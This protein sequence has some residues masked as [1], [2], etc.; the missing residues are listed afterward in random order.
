MNNMDAWLGDVEA[1]D[2]QR[3]RIDRAATAIERRYPVPADGEPSDVAEEREAAL[4]AAAQLILGDL[5]LEELAAA[6]DTAHRRA[7][8]AHAARTG[9]LIAEA[10]TS[11][12][13]D[14]HRRTGLSR[15]TIDK[16][17]G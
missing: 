16:A 2:E 4:S 9:A 17:L 14:I 13:I 5:Q 7:M 11:P 8:L 12:K 15:P 6:Y 3:D 10:Q 1:T